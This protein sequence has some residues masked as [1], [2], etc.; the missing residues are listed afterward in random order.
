MLLAAGRLILA[1]NRRLFRGENGF[2]VN[3]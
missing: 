3:W 1:D 2:I